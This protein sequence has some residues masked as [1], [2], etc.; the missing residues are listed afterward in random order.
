MSR[1]RILH[2]H[3]MSSSSC[4]SSSFV[5]F[6]LLSTTVLLADVVV[7]FCPRPAPPFAM[8]RRNYQGLVVVPVPQQ[9]LQ[10]M[11][12]PNDKDILL[13]DDDDD[14]EYDQEEVEEDPYAQLATSEF[15]DDDKSPSSSSALTTK[16][17][18]SNSDIPA[19]GMDWGGALGQLRKRVQDVDSGKAQ[20]PSH[21]LFRTMSSQ[22]PN[23]LIGKFVTSANPQ[24]VQAMSGAVQSLL[25][26]LSNPTSGMDT[27]VR[28]SG[29]KIGSLCFQLQMTGYV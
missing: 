11:D 1:T 23:Q 22:T 20:D 18:S 21:V 5:M 28:A 7:A 19:T 9:P 12:T 14:D 2:T 27:L 4:L 24:V 13:D 25:G 10:S 8:G 3:K 29:E 6:A 26:G 16:T 15:Q 17:T